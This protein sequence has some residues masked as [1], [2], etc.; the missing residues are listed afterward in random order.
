MAPERIDP[1]DPLNPVY[2]IRADVWSLG[3]T[4]VELATG[5]YP[6]KHCNNEFEVMSTILQD[7]SP[8]LVGDHFSED[9]KNFVAK[10]LVKNV[11]D[12]PKYNALMQEPFVVRYQQTEVDVKSWIAKVTHPIQRDECVESGTSIPFAESALLH[13]HRTN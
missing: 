13:T 2:D 7:E 3:I 4:L 12:R 5:R 10:C 11:Q 6:Y 8:K 1:V 9:F